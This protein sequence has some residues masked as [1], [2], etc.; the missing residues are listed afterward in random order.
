MSAQPQA[1]HYLTPQE[2]LEIERRAEYKSEYFDGEMFAMAG[3]SPAHNRVVANTLTEIN[4]QFKKRPC[5]AYANDL[6]VKISA[7]GLYTYPDIVALC[8]PPRFEDNQKDTLLNPTVIIEV[9]SDSTEAYDRGK[10]FQH[11]RTL[12][13]LQ[14]YVLISQHECRV[15]HY[16][17]QP[18][19]QWT[20]TETH[21]LAEV[22]QLSAIQCQLALADIYDKVGDGSL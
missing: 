1:I 10:K 15:E 9:L 19:N 8:G 17:R 4:L 16:V 5:L 14:E 21:D 12:E 13:S 6:R 20:L 7:T 22:I 18:G 3:A 2:Y 11:Y